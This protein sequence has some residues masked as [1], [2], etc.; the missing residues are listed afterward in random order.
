MPL[1]NVKRLDSEEANGDVVHIP[2]NYR[3]GIPRNSMAILQV[4]KIK[5]RLYVL[6][7][8]EDEPCI[9][10][11]LTTRNYFDVHTGE[12][13]QFTIR[14]CW[15]GGTL[16]WSMSHTNPALR[17]AS[18]LG[19]VSLILGVVSII[20]LAIE[21]GPKLLALFQRIAPS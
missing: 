1:L 19:V 4:G 11:D 5:K 18:Q 2:K 10:M 17:I 3:E 21:Y 12:Q 6:G 15:I 20:P 7:S 14:K 9:F 13:V 8:N 16:F